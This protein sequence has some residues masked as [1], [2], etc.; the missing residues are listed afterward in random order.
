L[1]NKLRRPGMRS[2]W[3]W[4]LFLAGAVGGAL[5]AGFLVGKVFF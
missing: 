1:N 3:F 5:V 2:P 4:R